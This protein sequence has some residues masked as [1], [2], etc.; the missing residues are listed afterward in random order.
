MICPQQL[1]IDG[2]PWE[3]DC[4]LKKFRDFIVQVGN[5]FYQ[6]I[7]L[8]IYVC[9]YLNHKVFRYLCNLKFIYKF[10]P[11]A[12]S[13]GGNLSVCICICTYICT[14]ICTCIC[15]LI[16]VFVFVIVLVKIC[17]FSPGACNSG[18]NLCICI[19]NCICENTQFSHGACSSG[20][21]LC[22]YRRDRSRLFCLQRRAEK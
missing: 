17:K 20:G 22:I 9:L 18:G 6:S 1:H 8:Q 12:R 14:C 3:C 15:I 16:C 13:L 5:F 21:N 19:C 10:L 4:H 2:N 7:F 11:G